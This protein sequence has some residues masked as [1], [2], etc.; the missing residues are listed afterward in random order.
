[1]ALP[2]VEVNVQ[3][4]NLGLLPQSVAKSMVYLGCSV[5][6]TENE[7]NFFGDTVAM[8]AELDVGEV[9]EAAA[10]ELAVTGGPVGVMTLP[11]SVAGGLSSVTHS[12]P[13]A[14]TMS[15]SSAPHKAITITITTT[16]ALN[17][18]AFTYQAGTGA[19]SQPVTLPSGGTFRVPGT[20]T[21]LTFPAGTYTATDIYSISILGVVTF[22]SG[23]GTDRSVTQASSPIDAY[24]PVI[25]IT[26]SGAL[27]TSQFTYSLDGT[28][29]NASAPVLSSAGGAYALPNT[30][31]VI[32]LS[33]TAT[34]GDTYSFSSAP[35]SYSNSELVTAMGILATTY[36][37]SSYSLATVI[38]NLASTT[39]WA[40]QCGSIATA[41]AALAAQG[42]YVRFFNGC[43]S[44]G[45]ITASGGAV[46]VNS[47]STDS[48]ILT[49]RL[50]V[51]TSAVAASA[52]DCLL[53][54]ALTGLSQRRNASWV[55]S[56]RAADVEASQN[57]G[58]VEDGALPGVT[59]IYRDEASTPALDAVGFI[60]LRTFAGSV[61]SGTG[62]AGFYITDGHTMDSVVSDYFPLTNARVI[63][64]GCTITRAA[65][66]PLVNSKVPTTTRNGNVGV[67][68]NA[69]ALK[70]E[71]IVNGKLLAGMVNI[72][73]Q[74]AV[75]TAV[76]VNRTNN[77]LATSTLILAVAIQPFG[78][79]KTI[80]VNIGL[81]VEA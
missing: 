62:L 41:R 18:G 56:A 49:S 47:T 48:A 29:A 2:G 42:L 3:N 8:Q 66:L 53:T 43:P 55:A 13:G 77:V 25:T 39:V 69:K 59:Y 70:I 1:M 34:A 76:T 15:V 74:E 52:G 80:V 51:S 64:L 30:G 68:T 60:T 22:T 20:Y 19:A 21:V 27:A 9:V 33:G 75:N 78:Y 81:T 44:L 54:S 45:S 24:T 6:G 14:A 23:G 67:I 26:K 16:G 71:G 61:S 36:L 50:T 32:T 28:A 72:E 5:A 4:G 12:G 58:A 57:I 38:G 79:A 37:S 40:T 10:Y 35:P 31:I 73:P 17:V 65:A 7:L 63:D 46:V 11:P